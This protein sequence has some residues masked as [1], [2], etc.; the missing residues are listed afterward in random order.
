MI[1]KTKIFPVVLIVIDL[2]A[3][4]IYAT[5]KDGGRLHIGLRRQSSM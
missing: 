3:A 1:D 2:A 5:T 4:V